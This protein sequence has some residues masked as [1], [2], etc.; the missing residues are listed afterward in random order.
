MDVRSTREEYFHLTTN[1]DGCTTNTELEFTG[2]MQE[3]H[4]WKS[5]ILLDGR[6]HDAQWNPLLAA[7]LH[8]CLVLKLLNVQTC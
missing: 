3:D 6:R 8:L 7:R 1:M 4:S 2:C 5:G